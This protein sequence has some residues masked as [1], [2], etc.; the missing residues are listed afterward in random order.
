MSEWK[1]RTNLRIPMATDTPDRHF[2]VVIPCAGSGSRASIGT[3]K[4]YALLNG[5]PMVVHALRSFQGVKGLGQSVLVVAPD[6][7]AMVDVLKQW[8]QPDFF[9]SHT[10][11]ATRAQSVL[12]GLNALKAKGVG[13]DEWVLVHD[14][15]RCL[16]TSELIEKLLLACFVDKVGGLLA[17]PLPDTLKSESNGRVHTTLDRTAKWLA[18]TPQMFRL[19]M[20]RHALMSAGD[21]VTDEASAM[22]M[23]GLSPL[24]VPSAAFNFKVTYA[25]DVQMA[26]AILA[27]RSQSTI[28]PT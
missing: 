28:A 22:E 6:D 4:Q 25:E 3:P 16:L 9:V 7:S 8:P 15:A 20:L 27:D 5:I 12:A 10:G 24:L 19:D 23:S 1:I 18:Q 21:S 17:L 26:Q 14:A 11:G 13:P 2:H